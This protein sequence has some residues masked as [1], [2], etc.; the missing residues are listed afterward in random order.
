VQSRVVTERFEQVGCE[1]TKGSAFG[2]A[3][4]RE[5]FCFCDEQHPEKSIS[6]NFLDSRTESIKVLV[7]DALVRMLFLFKFLHLVT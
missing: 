4:K 5:S 2:K 3:K 7:R 1:D 6:P